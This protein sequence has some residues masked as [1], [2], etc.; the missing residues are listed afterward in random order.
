MS[1]VCSFVLISSIFP[2]LQRT[3]KL[4]SVVLMIIRK[5][6]HLRRGGERGFRVTSTDCLKTCWISAMRT[7]GCLMKRR[8]YACSKQKRRAGWGRQKKVPWIRTGSC[9]LF[10]PRGTRLRGGGM[11]LWRLSRRRGWSWNLWNLPFI[12]KTSLRSSRA[13]PSTRKLL[14]RRLSPISTREL[15]MIFVNCTILCQTRSLS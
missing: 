1:F 10:G 6:G 5:D 13:R 11:K 7:R 12:E 2:T 15:Y 8:A 9:L 4:V 3:A 14:M